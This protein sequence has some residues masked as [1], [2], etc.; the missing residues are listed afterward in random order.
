[1]SQKD[2][3]TPPSIRAFSPYGV[4]DKPRIVGGFLF[5]M[6]K[7]ID[8]T[9]NKYGRLTVVSI[10][11]KAPVK[12]NV[13]CECGAE[14]VVKTAKLQNGHTKSCGCY[15]RDQRIASI[16]RHGLSRTPIHTAWQEMIGRCN[17]K[18]SKSYYYYGAR[19]IRVCDRWLESFENFYADMSP[20]PGKGYSIDRID[21]NGNYEPGNCR[22][23]TR[24]EQMNNT[25]KTVF[26]TD[27]NLTMTLS[28]WAA[29]LN[30]PYDSIKNQSRKQNNKYNLKRIKKK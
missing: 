24:S 23:A 28:E 22:W 1:M 8:I 19:G 2:Y 7:F 10:H 4:D 6:P 16:T 12:W 15:G 5:V 27:G 13:I 26:C 21:N 9:G 18:N 3:I 20:H 11:S 25:R 30:Q 29:L 17:N 14:R